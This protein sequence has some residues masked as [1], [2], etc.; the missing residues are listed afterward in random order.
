MHPTATIA[1]FV[2]STIGS[3]SEH[4][5]TCKSQDRVSDRQCRPAQGK[6]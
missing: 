3:R 6:R 1:L 2:A 5:I 4:S